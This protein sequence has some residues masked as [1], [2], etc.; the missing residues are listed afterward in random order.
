MAKKKEAEVILFASVE[1]LP[2]PSSHCIRGHL[3]KC[4]LQRNNL[5]KSSYATASNPPPSLF[6]L[7]FAFIRWEVVDSGMVLSSQE[8]LVG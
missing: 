1:L 7:S 5:H 3:Q 6:F 2:H 4:P 8:P